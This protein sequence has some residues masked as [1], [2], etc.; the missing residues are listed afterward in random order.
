MRS[1]CLF[2]IVLLS[3]ASNLTARASDREWGESHGSDTMFGG[4]PDRAWGED[5]PAFGSPEMIEELTRQAQ[6]GMPVENLRFEVGELSTEEKSDMV[7]TGIVANPRNAIGE[8]VNNIPKNGAQSS[9]GDGTIQY[10]KTAELQKLF[11]EYMF[12]VVRF[13]KYP[14]SRTPPDGLSTSNIFIAKKT[15]RMSLIASTDELQAFFT[16]TQ[17]AESDSRARLL[18][19][20]WLQLATELI[21]DGM[22][23][24]SI[25]DNA[26]TVNVSGTEMIANGKAAV[27]Q[28]AG[29]KGE[30]FV[31]MVFDAGGK[32]RAVEEKN[33][34]QPGMRP[35]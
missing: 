23:K 26:V 29:N 4:S 33:T 32:L 20:T 16:T 34:V 17:S 31:T 28:A 21:Q 22:Y 2:L 25:A 6:S 18:I 7:R 5:R 14:I 13:P 24:F 15:G 11:P 12:Y 35:I 3:A 9:I 8:L 30:V 1:V 10:V 19:Y 27:D